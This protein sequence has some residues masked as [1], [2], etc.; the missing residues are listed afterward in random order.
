MFMEELTN[1]IPALPVEPG[2]QAGVVSGIRQRADS[3]PQRPGG[4]T[5]AD[6]GPQQLLRDPCYQRPL[7]QGVRCRATAV[8]LM[9]QKYKT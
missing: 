6:V 4:G 7:Q 5:G 1:V 2:V 3:E 8:E 9:S